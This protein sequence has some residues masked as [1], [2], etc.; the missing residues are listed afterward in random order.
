V[1]DSL[2]NEG[3]RGDSGEKIAHVLLN[4]PSPTEGVSARNFVLCPSDT[5][6][7]SPCGTGTSAQLAVLH[8]RGELRP[9]EV[10]RQESFT[11]SVFSGSY[12]LR[13]GRVVPTL[14]GSAHV[15]A[16]GELRFEA[17]DPFADGIP[18]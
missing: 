4:G 6:D 9:G 2:A 5:Y 14:R 16:V 15:T 10:W 18:G 1:R 11:G 3:I 13:E 17:D 8:A 7:R 12:T